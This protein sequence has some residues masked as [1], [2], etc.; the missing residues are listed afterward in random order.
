MIRVYVGGFW[1]F[2]VTNAAVLVWG[3]CLPHW[4]TSDLMLMYMWGLLLG[5]VYLALR[6][7]VVGVAHRK[8]R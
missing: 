6:R 3:R 5:L 1:A 7:L 4:S 8:R 2:F